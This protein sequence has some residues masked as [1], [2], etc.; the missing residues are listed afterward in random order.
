MSLD[1]LHLYLFVCLIN[2]QVKEEKYIFFYGGKD[3]D[4]IQQFTKKATALANDAFI[5][6]SKINI[7]LFCV[8]KT[9][10]GGED[11]G[12]L[13]RFWS[14]IESLFFTKSHKEVD[15]VTQEIQKLLAYKNESGWAV[16]SKGSAVVTAGHG[17]AMLKVIEEFEQWK[18]VI[19]VK[20]FEV[21]FKEYHTKV[22]HSIRHCCRLDVPTVAG[23]VPDSMKCPECPRVM[24]TYISYKC[25]HVDSP[26]NAH[27]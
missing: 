16:L 18:E 26:L 2:E 12:I 14:G 27:H 4:L 13:G 15:P 8:G 24:E 22:T 25:C 11:H 9:A 19:K 17:L 5:K 20:G 10:K 7:E 6:E 23:K 21:A 3:N 1:S